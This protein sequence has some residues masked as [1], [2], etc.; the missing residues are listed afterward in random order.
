V[1]GTFIVFD[2]LDA[3]GKGEMVKRTKEWLIEKGISKENIIV[4]F[5]P[6]DGVHGKKLRELLHTDKDP[7]KNAKLCLELYVKDRKE[8][9]EELILP[10][11]AEG[12]IVLCDR[13]KY[14]TFVYQKLQGIS[15]EKIQKMHIGF[16]VP[17]LVLIFDVNAGVAIERILNDSKRKS[18]DKFEKK[19]FLENVR[20]E[21]L[22][23]KKLF[24]KE[25]IHIVDAG[26]KK[27]LVFVQVKH[28]A[29]AVIF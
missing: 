26:K 15:V 24:P 18:F 16:L 7:L 10:A 19:S 6:T 28:L 2:G 14:S 25:N 3:S 9:L 27:E 5:E 21:F 11:L 20:K 1:S 13:Y 8:H 29:G 22:N 4:T 17:D 12:K 23:Q